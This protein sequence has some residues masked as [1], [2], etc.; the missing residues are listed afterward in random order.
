M[1]S[2]TEQIGAAVRSVSEDVQRVAD[3]AIQLQ[4][5]A[6]EVREHSEAVR[7]E[8][9]NL[10]EGLGQFQLA[11]HQQIRQQV[12]TLASE[13]ALLRGVT[14]AERLMAQRIQQDPRFELMY[15]V[16]ADGTQA[17]E[18]V[19][20]ADLADTAKGSVRGKNWSTRPWFREVKEQQKPF[21]SD[22]YRSSATDA[23]CFTLSAPVFDENGTLRYVLGADVRLSALLGQTAAPSV[24][25]TETPMPTRQA[26]PAW[27]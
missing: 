22:V 24:Q 5:R 8:S 26:A 11:I 18:N 12:E 9:D 16:A 10:L 25:A 6:T 15:L 3:V 4:R 13:P 27:A 7:S 17:S 20:A 23:F 19:L 14:E 21:I 1:A 2:G